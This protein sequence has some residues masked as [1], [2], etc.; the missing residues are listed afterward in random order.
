MSADFSFETLPDGWRPDTLG[1]LFD[2][3]Q[4]KALSPEAR[5]GVSRRPFLRTRNVFWG[6]LDLADVDTMSFDENEASRLTLQDRDLLVC[7]GGEIG[8]TAIWRGEL[9]GCLYQNHIHRL[10]RKTDEVDPL[11]VMYWLQAAFLQ[12]GLY[13]GIGNRTTIPNLSGARLKVL[14]VAVPSV[15]EQGAIADLLSKL[16]AAVDVEADRVAALKELKAA[17]MAKLFAEGLNGETSKSTEIGAIPQSWQVVPLRDLIAEAQYGLSQRGE[18]SGKMPILRMNS[19][20]DGRIVFRDLQFVDVSDEVIEKY[21]LEQGDLLFN[22]TNS[23]DLVGRTAIFL[24]GRK[25]VFASYLIRLRP[26]NESVDSAF[27]NHYLN[28]EPTQLALKRLA[29]RGVSQSNINA[30]KLR[31]FLVPRPRLEEQRQISD[32][33]DSLHA[34]IEEA[35]ELCA[36]LKRLFAAQLHAL[37]TGEVRVGL[38]MESPEVT[39]A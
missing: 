11:F 9:P 5:G 32:I 14:P 33:L 25:A 37:M 18:K 34:R 35:I 30:S 3:Q 20:Q 2:V 36:S 22:R 28:F 7:E 24:G 4:G 39:G 27:L 10:R 13:E 26:R 1:G 17:T 23:I 29:T 19:Q 6:R 21:L 16:H 15:R 38:V 8:R 12:L 31:T